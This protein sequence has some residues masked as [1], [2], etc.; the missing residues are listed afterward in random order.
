[1]APFNTR[2]RSEEWPHSFDHFF[3]GS[4]SR[5]SVCNRAKAVALVSVHLFVF[6]P[7]NVGK[8]S[9][10]TVNR[11]GG[12]GQGEG[13]VR[14]CQR[15]DFADSI[16]THQTELFPVSTRPNSRSHHLALFPLGLV[17]FKP[18]PALFLSGRFPSSILK[19][20]WICFPSPFPPLFRATYFTSDRLFSLPPLY[21]T[22]DARSFPSVRV[23]SIL[24]TLGAE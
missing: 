14:R 15:W 20:S 6:M 7:Q 9:L 4:G 19:V 21:P 16:F 5:V 17:V 3:S 10:F 13:E 24:N 12:G 1:M 23:S 11:R 22:Q 2:R 18:L 8:A